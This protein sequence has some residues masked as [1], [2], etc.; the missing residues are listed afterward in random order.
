MFWYSVG[1]AASQQKE[2]PKKVFNYR[3]SSQKDWWKTALGRTFGNNKYNGFIRYKK[4]A[5][6]KLK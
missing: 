2:K 1:L 3:A 4:G 5:F 6:W